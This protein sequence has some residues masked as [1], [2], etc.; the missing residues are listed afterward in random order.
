[1]PGTHPENW[2]MIAQ[3]MQKMDQFKS[4][5][6]GDLRQIVFENCVYNRKT[7]RRWPST[8]DNLTAIK[9]IFIDK[10]IISR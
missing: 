3:K 1:M 4:V 8:S 5:K 10:V 9:V 7:P 6:N 2:G